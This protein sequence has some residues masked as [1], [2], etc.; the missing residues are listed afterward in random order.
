MV[1][2]RSM[3]E[4]FEASALTHMLVVT[5][6]ERSR[7]WYQRVLDAR[8]FGEYGGTS[9]VLELLDSWI[10]L[11]TGGGPDAGKPNVT[12][13][14]PPTLTVLA[15]SSSF[16]LTTAWGFTSCCRIVA[17]SSWPHRTFATAR[18]V[19]SFETQTVICSRFQNSP[20]RRPVSVWPLRGN[21]GCLTA[22]TVPLLS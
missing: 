21:S 1:R 7:D 4:R 22:P 10:L 5:D 19:R 8:V 15:P 3:V 14:P 11:V 12:L 18:R 13:A 6:V 16:G 20:E 2:Y 9:V 17:L